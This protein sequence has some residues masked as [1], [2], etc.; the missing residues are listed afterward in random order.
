MRATCLTYYTL[1][2]LARL[3]NSLCITVGIAIRRRVGRRRDSGASAGVV[4]SFLFCKISKPT[5]VFIHWI[6][7][8][9]SPGLMRPGREADQS[10]PFSDK[11]NNT[12]DLPPV[13]HTS[14]WA[15]TRFD[16]PVYRQLFSG[17]HHHRQLSIPVPDLQTEFRPCTTVLLRTRDFTVDAPSWL[18][19]YGR[20]CRTLTM[21]ASVYIVDASF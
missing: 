16:F 20:N 18:P 6:K 21:K 5:L 10:S 19:C 8:I 3:W 17:N 14:S 7:R 11:A 4:N 2:G 12:W 1:F 13:S 15:A 9:T